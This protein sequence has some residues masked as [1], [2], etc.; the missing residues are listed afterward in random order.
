MKIFEKSLSFHILEVV[1]RNYFL[2]VLFQIA[3]K[4]FIQRK[5]RKKKKE[6][7]GKIILFI[8]LGINQK[9]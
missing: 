5:G 2:V 8:F 9:I 6:K 4:V 7:M 3:Q 1:Q